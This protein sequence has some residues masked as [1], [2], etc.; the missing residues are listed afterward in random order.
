MTHTNNNPPSEKRFT[1]AEMSDVM[2]SRKRQAFGFFVSQALWDSMHARA[3]IEQG[4]GIGSGPI[5]M[6]G[7]QIAVDPSLPDTEFDV[8][9]TADAWSRRLSALP[10]H[11]RLSPEQS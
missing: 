10:R 8:A 5:A 2:M 3:V 6:H 11:Q 1:L 4:Y 9:F 7:V